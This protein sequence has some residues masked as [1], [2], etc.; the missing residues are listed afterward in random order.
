MLYLDGKSVLYTKKSPR[1]KNY[2]TIVTEKLP[3]FF[4]GMHEVKE[5]LTDKKQLITLNWIYI[6]LAK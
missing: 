5:K 1:K 2:E 3:F 4:L 6:F